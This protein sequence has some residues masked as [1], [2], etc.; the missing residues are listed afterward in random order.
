MKGEF[1]RHINMN[2]SNRNVRCLRK[3]YVFSTNTFGRVSVVYNN[4]LVVSKCLGSEL[5]TLRF[6]FKRIHIDVDVAC[7]NVN[8]VQL[9][10]VCA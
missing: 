8:R 3:L 4:T 6:C 2:A 9:C 7:Q 10:A 1:Q 5:Y